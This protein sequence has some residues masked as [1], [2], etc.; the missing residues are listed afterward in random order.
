M[1][2]D[3]PSADEVPDWVDEVNGAVKTNGKLH[4]W[5]NDPDLA[6]GVIVSDHYVRPEYDGVTRQS[7]QH[8]N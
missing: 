5:S 8:T 4:I 7:S 2:P 3:H 1:L 6:G